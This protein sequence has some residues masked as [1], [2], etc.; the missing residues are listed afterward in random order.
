MRS[1]PVLSSFWL[2]LAAVSS[3]KE[4]CFGLLLNPQQLHRRRQS[5]LVAAT[6]PPTM[7]TTFTSQRRVP[8]TTG[9]R[10][11][12][13]D[14]IDAFDDDDDEEEVEP[15][16]MRVSEI[17]A[18]LELREVPYADCFD[19]E[20]LVKRLEEARAAGRADPS[21]LEKFNKQK[22]EQTFKGE[23][24]QVKDE[25]IDMAVSGD[26]KLPGGMSPDTFKKLIE[27]PEIMTLLQ[28]TKMQEAMKLMMTGGRDELEQKLK[29]DPELQKT[30]EKLNTVLRSVQ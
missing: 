6:A 16:K 7:V 21:I 11:T 30:V 13:E 14:L 27:N 15:G 4:G 20:S 25:D 23:Q 9:L 12:G 22:L 8:T 28:S 1:R 29:D 5:V 10:S 18:E 24:L 3:K 26:G 2:L 19:K 17:K